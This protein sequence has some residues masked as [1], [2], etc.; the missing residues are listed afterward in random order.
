LDQSLKVPA[1]RHV[2]AGL[3]KPDNSAGIEVESGS[4]KRPA[5]KRYA[6]RSRLRST[7]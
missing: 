5:V 6:D 2:N 7:A 4:K 1:Y 3:K